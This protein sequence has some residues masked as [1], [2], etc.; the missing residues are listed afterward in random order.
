MDA[1][2][3]GLPTGQLHYD[4]IYP[5]LAP[6][7][8]RVITQILLILLHDTQTNRASHSFLLAEGPRYASGRTTLRAQR[9]L[10]R[11]DDVLDTARRVKYRFIDVRS[12][13]SKLSGNCLVAMGSGRLHRRCAVSSRLFS[14][15]S[16]FLAIST[17]RVDA[18]RCSTAVLFSFFVFLGRRR[19]VRRRR[20]GCSVVVRVSVRHL[21]LLAALSLPI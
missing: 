4:I 12:L 18:T 16:E 13:L 15:G 7:I 19:A 17:E 6:R 11:R 2:P 3:T 9:R 14:L 10:H 5:F 8:V 20:R 1:V 21:V